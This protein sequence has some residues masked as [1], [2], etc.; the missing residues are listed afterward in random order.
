MMVS[1][2][3]LSAIIPFLISSCSDEQLLIAQSKNAKLY[4]DRQDRQLTVWERSILG[5]R[6]P[7]TRKL[8]GCTGVVFDYFGDSI[9]GNA[10]SLRILYGP[11]PSQCQATV[12]DNVGALY[13]ITTFACDDAP[14]IHTSKDF[15]IEYSPP[16]STSFDKGTLFYSALKCLAAHS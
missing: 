16:M 6:N 14:L 7:E 9:I 8:N 3:M 2:V 13:N 4:K 1:T 15:V 12:F 11:P 5:K 10:L